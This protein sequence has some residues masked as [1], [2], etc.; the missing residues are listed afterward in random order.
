MDSVQFGDE[1]AGFHLEVK[2]QDMC[3]TCTAEQVW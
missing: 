1:N 2:R 3:Y